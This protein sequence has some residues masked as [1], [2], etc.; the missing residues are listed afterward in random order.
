MQGE[1]KILHHMSRGVSLMHN[2][3][4]EP[5][6]KL[7]TMN[8]G[9]GFIIYDDGEE[10]PIALFYHSADDP[11]GCDLEAKRRREILAYLEEASLFDMVKDSHEGG[12]SLKEC[13]WPLTN[14]TDVLGILKG[15]VE[16]A[17]TYQPLLGTTKEELQPHG[18]FLENWLA[19]EKEESVIFDAYGR[20]HGWSE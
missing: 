18:E 17:P 4:F 7:V 6:P 14:T 15:E 20:E 5:E 13:V 3:D 8:I 19:L 2:H 11:E 1:K 10:E 16:F 12:P 9:P